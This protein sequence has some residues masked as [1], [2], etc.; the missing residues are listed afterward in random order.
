MRTAFLLCVTLLAVSLAG[1]FQTPGST[2][3]TDDEPYSISR[4]V[5]VR[6]DA[7][8]IQRLEQIAEDPTL[9]EEYR[10]DFLD[11][12]LVLRVNADVD[13][14]KLT[15]TYTDREGI[16]RTSPVSLLTGAPWLNPGATI[17]VPVHMFSGGVLKTVTGEVLA[18]RTV[19]TPAW[20]T[21]GGYPL[22]I[23]MD[24]GAELVYDLTADARQ[25]FSLTDIK[26][27]DRELRY[28]LSSAVADI[29][30]AQRATLTLA[31]D[32]AS[33][34]IEAEERQ[35]ARPLRMSIDGSVSL[36]IELSFSGRNLSEDR[37][38]AGGIEARPATGFNYSADGKLW[39]N[40]TNEPVRFDV[41]SA[42]MT[43][44]LDV[45]AWLTGMPEAEDHFSCASKTRLDQCR[46]KEIP[47]D[48]FE[49]TRSFGPDSWN[50]DGIHAPPVDPA[51]LRDL[52]QFLADDLRPGDEIAYRVNLAGDD[53]PGY[54]P[55]GNYPEK[56]E[57]ESVTRVLGTETVTVR[58]GTF[59]TY[60]VDQLFRF[61][62]VTPEIR[63][64]DG[65][66]FERLDVDQKVIE[67]STWIDTRNFAIVKSVVT[68]PMDLGRIADQ[69]LDALDPQ[70]WEGSPI[71]RLTG[72]NVD[73]TTTS[74]HGMELAKTTGES[75]FSP[76]VLI[77]GL[78]L[79]FLAEEGLPQHFL[80]DPAE[81]VAPAWAEE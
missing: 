8:N 31:Y 73:L 27:T 45:I 56:I 43:G 2:V 57:I 63:G 76:W 34:T 47:K 70:V 18:D 38:I 81:Y 66:V 6:V 80:E 42:S 41:D 1:C 9:L 17:V 55:Y 53:I 20:W 75:R 61:R 52:E 78:P 58:A 33:E 40:T 25:R 14:K 35:Q 74:T 39:W 21:A 5:G 77:G 54:T 46:P 69:V 36:P 23:S 10:Y 50:L 3:T 60:K 59:E 13:P 4:V 44:K 24:P 7:T 62:V 15:F 30:T 49:Q 26:P 32:A 22:G 51:I 68:M 72:S 71:E 16:E 64:D 28:H 48:E 79:F 65:S 11:P 29:A 19:D 67:S 12:Q 37:A